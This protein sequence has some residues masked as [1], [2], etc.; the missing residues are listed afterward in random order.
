MSQKQQLGLKPQTKLMTR[1]F[2]SPKLKQNLHILMLNSNNLISYLN[3]FTQEN[4]FVSVNYHEKKLQNLDWIAQKQESLTDH[5][6]NQVKINLWSTKEKKIVEYLIYNLDSNG[7]LR[8]RL[9]ELNAKSYF[10]I[11]ELENAIKQLQ[12]LTPTGVGAQNL[13]ECLL[14]QAEKKEKFDLVALKILRQNKLEEL[15]EPASWQNMSFSREELL[16]ALSEIQTLNPLPSAG[17]ANGSDTQYLI[18][19]FSYQIE[20]KKIYVSATDVF[21]PE[22][23]F[24]QE[25]F[26]QLRSQADQSEKRYFS[27]QQATYLNLQQ[28]LQQRKNTILEIAKVLGLYQS[29]YLLSLEKQ[30]LKPI[31]LKEIAAKLNL[32]PSTV[33]RALKDKYFECQKQIISCK[34]LLARKS[35]DQFSQSQVLYLLKRIINQENKNAP[36]SDKEIANLLIKNGI[37]LSRRVI[38]KYRKALKIPNSYERKNLE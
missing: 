26:N 16:A 12:S 28:A 23:I 9:D 1:L 33:S 5:L 13:T 3:D 37:K 6:L 38:S 11:S 17:F 8:V 24:D 36:L 20:D 25:K 32:A 27:T 22:L 21:S 30:N 2:L 35:R 19:D 34:T 4:P 7:Y 18:P 10:S 14:L 15:A 31:G 29:S